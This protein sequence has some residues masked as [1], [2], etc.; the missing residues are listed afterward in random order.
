MK[1]NYSCLL[2]AIYTNLRVK[3]YYPPLYPHDYMVLLW[4][5]FHNGL[6]D[7]K[8]KRGAFATMVIFIA[9]ALVPS[10]MY[11]PLVL[12]CCAAT[13]R[14]LDPLIWQRKRASIKVFHGLCDAAK[15]AKKGNLDLSYLMFLQK[16]SVMSI[17]FFC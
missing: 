4:P 16:D 13:F 17:S 5:F 15:I 6:S 3:H 10:F 2:F 12:V 7:S 1:N 9:F 14:P 11:L 8:R